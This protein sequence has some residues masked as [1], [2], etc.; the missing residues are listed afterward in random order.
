M[1]RCIGIDP[2]LGR[3][4]VAAVAMDGRVFRLISCGCIETPPGMPLPA[5]LNMIFKEL[6]DHIE[7]CTPDF[8]S[9]EKLFFG[10]NITT[11]ESVWQARGVALLQADRYNLPVFEPKPSQIKLAVCGYGTAPKEQVQR[12]SQRLLG[13][14]YLPKPDDAADAIGAAITGFSLLAEER[15]IS[16]ARR[17][18]A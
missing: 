2:G 18:H 1:L 5:R 9:I 15:R 16:G 4:G 10:K 7:E 14:S 17:D 6:G 12:M 13:L 8:M 3:M 11:A